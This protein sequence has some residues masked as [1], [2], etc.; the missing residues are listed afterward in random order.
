MLL[1]KGL[2]KSRGC[3]LAV[4]KHGT[5]PNMTQVGILKDSKI[6]WNS[7]VSNLDFACSQ[8]WEFPATKS[9]TECLDVFWGMASTNMS[10][11]D[12][13]TNK[14]RPGLA[15]GDGLE[16]NFLSTGSPLDFGRICQVFLA[17]FRARKER[18]PEVTCRTCF[19]LEVLVLERLNLYESI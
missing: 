14:K 5:F 1:A 2:A 6:I 8:T 10:W 15:T 12:E 18:T 4:Q 17:K 3:N 9:R 16:I 19:T 13:R 7:L 11:M